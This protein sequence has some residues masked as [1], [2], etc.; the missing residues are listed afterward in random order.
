MAVKHP[1]VKFSISRDTHYA[2]QQQAAE[3][4]VHVSV[5]VEALVRKHLRKH[6]PTT[7]T[8]DL[9]IDI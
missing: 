2:L 7:K 5:V 8:P 6:L 9:V 1:R 4:G 3:L